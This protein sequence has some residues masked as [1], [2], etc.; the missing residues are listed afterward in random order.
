[1]NLSS[2][3]WGRR[4]KEWKVNATVAND[5]STAAVTASRNMKLSLYDE[6]KG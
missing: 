1:V 6:V 5:K 2:Q 4:N 3:K